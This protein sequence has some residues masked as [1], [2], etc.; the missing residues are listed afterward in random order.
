ML[1]RKLNHIS[2]LGY[3]TAVLVKGFG[4]LYSYIERGNYLFYYLT[5]ISVLSTV[6]PS[7]KTWTAARL[8]PL[9]L[10]SAYRGNIAV[11]GVYSQKKRMYK[12]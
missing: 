9:I 5:T 4:K 7:S 1:R 8:T 6:V 11:S 12:K 10:I 3:Y 2:S